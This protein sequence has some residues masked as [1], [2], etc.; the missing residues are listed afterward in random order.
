MPLMESRIEALQSMNSTRLFCGSIA[1][2]VIISLS[3]VLVNRVTEDNGLRL[4]VVAS[5]A[6][7][8]LLGS[9]IG[10][11]V[12]VKETLQ[13]HYNINAESS[14]IIAETSDA[15]ARSLDSV[16]T[17]VDVVAAKES[18]HPTN[19]GFKETWRIPTYFLFRSKRFIIL[20]LNMFFFWFLIISIHSTLPLLSRS[21]FPVES[22]VEIES[23][24]PFSSSTSFQA[25]LVIVASKAGTALA[26]IC[27][28]VFPTSLRPEFTAK[29]SMVLLLITSL[30]F[31]LAYHPCGSYSLPPVSVYP[32]TFINGVGLG[33]L[34]S[35]FEIMVPETVLYS[36]TTISPKMR[37]K[38]ITAH[39]GWENIIYAWVDAARQ[40]SLAISFLM[41]GY[42]LDHRENRSQ[43]HVNGGCDANVFLVAEEIT[44]GWMPIAVVLL[45]ALLHMYFP[46]IIFIRPEIEK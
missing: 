7:A 30:F 25:S 33:G 38:D 20:L 19:Y 15:D 18:T 22:A 23:E 29:V 27:M 46:R 24:N 31:A 21:L 39:I 2:L 40:L 1:G 13:D 35:S 41:V 6:S 17:Q 44:T 37:A 42:V 28:S 36:E 8:T 9:V 14:F 11:V 32:V 4:L 12:S 45:L 10:W 5:L 3:A 16:S 26:Q 43:I 34:F